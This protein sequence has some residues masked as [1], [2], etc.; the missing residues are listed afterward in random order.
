MV[1]KNPNEQAATRLSVRGVDFY[2]GDRHALKDVSM[3]FADRRI[4]AIVGPSGCGKSTLLRIF[5]RIYSLYPG[6]RATGS[7]ML[8]GEDILANQTPVNELRAKVGMVLQ[9]PTPFPL[10]VRDNIALAVKYHEKLN[11]V[12]VEERVESALRQAA[13][14]DEVKAHLNKSA[15]SLSGGQQQRLCIARAIAV[16]P[17]IILMDEPTSAL[18]PIAT[19]KIEDLLSELEQRYTIII[20]THN[21]QQ[22]ARVSEY[23]AFMLMGR[24]VEIG[25]TERIFTDPSEK[26]TNAYVT[27]RFG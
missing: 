13:L 15:L 6:Q 25:P 5:N 10:S 7:V 20:V 2:Y 1:H 11:R 14:W 8:D 16:Q 9:T 12:D 19:L 4:T 17:E 27:G 23:T 22:A 3:D 26:E 21:L 18:D 24:L